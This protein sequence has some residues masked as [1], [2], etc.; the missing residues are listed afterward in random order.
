M[1]ESELSPKMYMYK[2]VVEAKLYIDNS[3][4]EKIDLNKISDQA[5]FS[6]YHF[7]RLFKSAF[8]KSPHKYLTEVRLLAAKKMLTE[9]KSIKATCF[10]VGFDSVP[11]FTI[12]F[13]KH[14][15]L[16]PNEFVD[17]VRTHDLDKQQK[18][19]AFVPNCFIQSYG[20]DK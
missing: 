17:K 3:Y 1:I 16:T 12:L 13:K 4:H 15:G 14:C 11:S 19:L 7:L 20:W 9:G 18:P 2:R 10:G 6:K 8:G 5:H